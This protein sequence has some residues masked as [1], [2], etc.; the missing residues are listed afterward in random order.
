MR[1]KHIADRRNAERIAAAWMIALG[2]SAAKVT[3]GGADAGV[4]VR[5][6]PGSRSPR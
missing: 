2:F 6:A 3:P 1:P 5:A 4:D